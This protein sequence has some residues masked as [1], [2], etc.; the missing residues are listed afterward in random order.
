MSWKELTR[1]KKIRRA[2]Q[3]ELDK[4]TKDKARVSVKH[5]RH[6]Q[7]EEE[8]AREIADEFNI[9]VRIRPVQK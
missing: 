1:N 7:Q 9:Q 6:K 4:G 5:L 2:Y 8:I 3:A